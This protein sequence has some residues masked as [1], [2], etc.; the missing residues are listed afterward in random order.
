MAEKE[1]ALHIPGPTPVEPDVLAAMGQQVRQ[2]YGDDWV[3]Y[4]NAFM[5]R[6]RQV[7]RTSAQVY[8]IPSSGTGGIEAMLSTL[9]G[10]DGS[11]G[12]IVNGF[13]GDRVR[14]IAEAHSP[15]V[16]T[17][18]VPWERP[19]D[20][21]EV[22]TWLRRTKVAMLAVV[23]SDTSTGV[24]NPVR[25]LAAAAREEG[26]AVAVDAVSSL[27]GMPIETDAWGLAGI[28]SASQKCLEAPPGLAPV[29]ITQTG[30]NVVD[31]QSAGPHGWYLNLR[32]WRE[33]QHIWPHHP[34]PVTLATNN[35]FALDRALE[36][37][38][39]EGLEARFARHRESQ[40]VL[41][42]GLERLGFT[43]LADLQWAS[44]TVT[45]AYPPK[46]VEAGAL[47]GTLRTQHNIAISGGL[48]QLAGKVIRIGHLGAQARPAL[49][50][51]I[52]EALEASLRE[53]AAAKR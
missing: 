21:G 19:A 35:I 34:Y 3:A 10:A 37:I 1:I 16:E 27:G 50:E 2:H 40:L 17:L 23:H 42:R 33:Y 24:I 29:A 12:V 22:R 38:L 15:R 28:S 31:R 11:V 49:M 25:E 46:G 26:V 4:Y 18:E 13:F 14:L 45:V 41:R 39:A 32:I 52:V 8:P 6:L 44:P 43:L 20:P 51:R 48:T 7:Y 53:Y 9:I 36:R 5:G 30:W 47:I